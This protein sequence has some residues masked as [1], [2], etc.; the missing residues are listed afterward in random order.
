[1]FAE[2]VLWIV[3]G[4]IDEKGDEPICTGIVRINYAE[5]AY[6]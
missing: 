5:Q 2:E 6:P 4:E 1:L 3:R